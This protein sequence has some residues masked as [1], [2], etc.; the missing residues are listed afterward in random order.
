M[1]NGIFCDRNRKNAIKFGG[2]KKIR[3]D[4][5]SRNARNEIKKGKKIYFFDTG[6]RNAIINNFS[7]LEMRN[8]VGALWENLLMVERRKRHAYS[9][10]FVQQY[11]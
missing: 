5:F 1:K 7:P 6:V 9:G 3:L 8:D 10:K 4:S 2:F 11:F